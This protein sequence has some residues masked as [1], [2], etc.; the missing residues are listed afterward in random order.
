[1]REK[2]S[3]FVCAVVLTVLRQSAVTKSVREK[4]VKLF[5]EF[6]LRNLHIMLNSYLHNSHLWSLE[7]MTTT[8]S[9][10]YKTSREK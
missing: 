2:L 7:F 4:L 5:I 10:C 9:I 8:A 3:E 1:M 6:S